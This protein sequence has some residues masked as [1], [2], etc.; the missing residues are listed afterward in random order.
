MT[1]SSRTPEGL[2]GEYPLCG[3]KTNIEF[4]DPAGDAPC[5]NCGCLTWASNQLLESI[6]ELYAEQLGTA[7][8]KIITNTRFDELGADS[9]DT[10]EMVM[11]LEAE[12]DVAIPDDAAEQMET[13]G[14]V[15]RYIQD[16]QRGTGV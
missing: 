1:V 3:A 8:D 16:H 10:V 11:E 4:S 9:L 13:I 5:P 6:A 7:H 15:V 12:F 14:D 2:P